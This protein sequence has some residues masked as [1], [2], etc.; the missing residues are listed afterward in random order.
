MFDE[1]AFDA[2]TCWSYVWQVLQ[3]HFKGLAFAYIGT[4]IHDYDK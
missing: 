3:D 2:S 1:C 4:G